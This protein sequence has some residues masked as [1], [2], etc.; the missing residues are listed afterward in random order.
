LDDGAALDERNGKMSAVP[1]TVVGDDRTA[2]RDRTTWAAWAV[3]VVGLALFL[4]VWSV[5]VEN[6]VL[7]GVWLP[8][9][10]LW[11]QFTGLMR[12]WGFSGPLIVVVWAL[13][14][15]SLV[16]SVAAVWF[17]FAARDDPAVSSDRTE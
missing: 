5:P 13:G 7:T 17:A 8:V 11:R 4:L 2:G 12:A 6:G 10:G 15:A 1:A 16:L 14:A 9:A 3:V